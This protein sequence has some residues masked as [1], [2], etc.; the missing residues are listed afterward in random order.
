MK[1][2]VLLVFITT[3]SPTLNAQNMWNDY[4]IGRPMMHYVES[5][6]AVAKEW[7]IQYKIDMAG[8][9]VSDETEK[10]MAE[11]D[12]QNEP[13]FKELEANFGKN[14]LH[15]FNLDVRK[16]MFIADS[17]SNKGVWRQPVI[18]KPYMQHFEAKKAVAAKWG[19]R[20]E[21]YFLGCDLSDESST[22][23][24]KIADESEEYLRSVAANFGEEWEK[25]FEKEVQLEIAKKNAPIVPMPDKPTANK[26]T[27]SECIIGKP[28]ETYFKAKQAVAKEWG[29][30][31]M[32]YFMG[33]RRMNALVK[34][35]AAV[36]KTNK[37]YLNS[38]AERYGADWEERFNIEVKKKY[39]GF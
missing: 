30:A 4:L 33:C 31:Y 37:I 21:P 7:G 32:P 19:I 2:I 12:K 3:L 10:K 23:A 35:Q 18:G 11:Y 14:W 20:Y 25:E 34:Q 26:A 13:Y 36:G 1:P 39:L 16:K 29:I 17:A 15:Y 24:Q 6:E 38:L 27:W 8:C 5:K 22:A 9:I 28:N